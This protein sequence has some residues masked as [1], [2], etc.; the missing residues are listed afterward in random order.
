MTCR[1]RGPGGTG[2]Q[3]QNVRDR[4]WHGVGDRGPAPMEL[5]CS[6]GQWCVWG[7]DRG[8]NKVSYQRK[9]SSVAYS[10]WVE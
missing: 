4:L 9:V 3:E 2:R 10:I 6:A 5:R 8:G 7:T 1:G